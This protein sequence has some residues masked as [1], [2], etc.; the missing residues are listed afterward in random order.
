MV[1]NL[2]DFDFMSS[3]SSEGNV[4]NLSIIIIMIIIWWREVLASPP[5][6]VAATEHMR[7]AS[8]VPVPKHTVHSLAVSHWLPKVCCGLATDL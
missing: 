8:S 1:A 5:R 2:V 7:V 4:T 6:I 3:F